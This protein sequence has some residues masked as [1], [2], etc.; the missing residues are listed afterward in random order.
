AD[1]KANVLFL[2]KSL[3]KYP[4]NIINNNFR[5]VGQTAMQLRKSMAGLIKS[6][7][8][9]LANY[10]G[11]IRLIHPE[12]ILKRGYS[13]TRF[14]GKVVYSHS[15]MKPGDQIETTLYKGSIKSKIISKSKNT[16]H[17]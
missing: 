14:N 13:I 2:N 1:E 3:V 12:N 9:E 6:K 5:A 17:G 10:E 8:D 16:D 11:K 15:E 4:G 7:H